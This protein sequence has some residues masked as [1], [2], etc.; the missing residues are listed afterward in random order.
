MSSSFAIH[1]SSSLNLAYLDTGAGAH[2]EL[3][4]VSVP[5]SERSMLGSATS[6]VSTSASR[7][8]TCPRRSN[9]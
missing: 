3:F 6:G 4:E 8:Q 5:T 9:G 2:L 1:P 7:S